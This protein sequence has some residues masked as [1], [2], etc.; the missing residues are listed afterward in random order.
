M[1]STIEGEFPSP[2]VLSDLHPAVLAR[3][4]SML[5]LLLPLPAQ[6]LR[7]YLNQLAASGGA[8]MAPMAPPP[9]APVKEDTV[10]AGQCCL[11][12]PKR[13]GHAQAVSSCMSMLKNQLGQRA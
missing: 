12:S 4:T 8:G 11:A 7:E 6:V 2:D 1:Q 13:L 10:G 9:A 5:A 3:F